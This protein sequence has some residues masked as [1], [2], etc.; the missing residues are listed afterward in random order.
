MKKEY[1]HMIQALISRASTT[2]AI[3]KGFAAKIIDSIA[4]LSY[5]EVYI[6]TLAVIYFFVHYLKDIWENGNEQYNIHLI[7]E[8]WKSIC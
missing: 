2:S 8:H 3:F 4:M 7:Y 6:D 1:V 5:A